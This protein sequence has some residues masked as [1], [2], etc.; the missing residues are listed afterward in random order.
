[1]RN[2]LAVGEASCNARSMKEL[3]S[4]SLRL[5]ESTINASSCVYFDITQSPDGLQF[6]ERESRGVPEQAPK[7][8]REEY[9]PVDPFVL[10]M[11]QQATN[12]NPLALASHE[13]IEHN[14]YINSDFYNT[15]LKP[16]SIYHVLVAG[17]MR[18]EK[19]VG[20]MGFHRPVGATPFSRRDIT[21]TTL[22]APQI[23][24]AAENLRSAD[25]AKTEAWIVDTLME[26]IPYQG[27][28]VLDEKLNV[29]YISDIARDLLSTRSC[30]IGQRLRNP[31]S[32]SSHN[33]PDFTH[34]QPD[35][36]GP[37][38]NCE[39]QKLIPVKI[40]SQ[41]K[42]MQRKS[43]QSTSIHDLDVTIRRIDHGLDGDRFILYFGAKTLD[44]MLQ[45][46]LV[47]FGLTNRETEVVRLVSA[48]M[49]NPE[50]ACELEISIRTVQNHLRSVYEKVGV[51]NRTSLLYQLATRG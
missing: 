38:I 27:I 3:C 2:L 36:L 20:L 25:V 7:L 28:A 42:E 5:M 43:T 15:F 16:Q 8:W 19:L 17:L 9:Q 45:D 44:I 30:S 18:H 51:H 11:I 24:A 29:I 22:A 46:R 34:F 14:D 4:D 40:R 49:T 23:A 31:A 12:G 6:N 32:K 35:S 39:D 33:N 1:M 10:T 41:C 21:L 50:V 13:L 47:H 37:V 48:G 26:A